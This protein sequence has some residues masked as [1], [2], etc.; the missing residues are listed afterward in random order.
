[1]PNLILSL[2]QTQTVSHKHYSD[3]SSADSIYDFRPYVQ[4][5]G[6][7]IYILLTLLYIVV[8]QQF[9][10]HLYLTSCL[11]AHNH[12]ICTHFPQNRLYCAKGGIFHHIYIYMMKKMCNTCNNTIVFWLVFVGLLLK[13]IKT[14][15]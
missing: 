10:K 7:C 12:N 3:L 6:I 15:D 13:S 9:D 8:S 1:M 4:F 14:I 11:N 5:Y 2:P